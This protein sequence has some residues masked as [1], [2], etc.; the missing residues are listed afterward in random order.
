MTQLPCVIN[1]DQDEHF[2]PATLELA[3]R[4]PARSDYVDLRFQ[5]ARGS[6]D[7]CFPGPPEQD[8]RLKGPLAL[9]I[10]A[11]GLQVHLITDGVLGP[12]LLNGP[13]LAMIMAGTEVSIARRLIRTRN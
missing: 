3:R 9:T 5:T 12:R 7:W 8:V 10:G 1:S 2:L 6:W 4:C 11:H 13:A